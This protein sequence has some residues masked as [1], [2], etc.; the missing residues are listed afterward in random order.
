MCSIPLI[1]DHGPF[2]PPDSAIGSQSSLCATSII[3]PPPSSDPYQTK[4]LVKD[5]ASKE[6]LTKM[7]AEFVRAAKAVDFRIPDYAD[8]PSD[9]TPKNKAAKKKKA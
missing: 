1:D 3:G 2:A 4:N 7:T 9:G 6:L 5:P 8:K